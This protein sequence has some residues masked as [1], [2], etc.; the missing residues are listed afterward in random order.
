MSL[1]V[2]LRHLEEID[3]PRVVIV[4]SRCRSHYDDYR[5]LHDVLDVLEEPG[6][7]V[8]VH[9]GVSGFEYAVAHVLENRH[10]ASDTFMPAESGY[11]VPR[12]ADIL[13]GADL[14]LCFHPVGEKVPGADPYIVELAV[15]LGILVLG[16]S[17][18][19]VAQLWGQ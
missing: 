10:T 2:V 13:D 16:I 4:G 3:T 7:I 15:A 18:G 12:E 8:L 6:P 19:G 9:S 5:L 11:S 17:K 1:D 14:L